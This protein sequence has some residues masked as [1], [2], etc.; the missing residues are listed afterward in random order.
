MKKVTNEN[1]MKEIKGLREDLN[2]FAEVMEILPM[3]HLP[4]YRGNMKDYSKRLKDYNKRKRIS[5]SLKQIKINKKWGKKE[6]GN[7]IQ[8]SKL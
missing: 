1:L 3:I 5:Y 7:D 4:K 2:T 8:K 6:H